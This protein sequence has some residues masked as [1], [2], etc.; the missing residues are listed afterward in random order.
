MHTKV[1]SR[2]FAT[3][4]ENFALRRFSNKAILGTGFGFLAGGA[5][6]WENSKV[7]NC[8]NN[9]FIPSKVVEENGEEWISVRN[10]P[11]FVKMPTQTDRTLH[12]VYK[13]LSAASALFSGFSIYKLLTISS[14]PA[15]GLLD[16]LIWLAG[17]LSGLFGSFLFWSNSGVIDAKK[18]EQNVQR[19]RDLVIKTYNLYDIIH[20]YGIYNA[21]EVSTPQELRAKLLTELNLAMHDLFSYEF[22]PRYKPYFHELVSEGIL[23]QSEAKFFTDLQDLHKNLWYE[24]ERARTILDKQVISLTQGLKIKKLQILP[25][26][27][28]LQKG[29]ERALKH[30]LDLISAKFQNSFAV[31]NERSINQAFLTNLNML[32]VRRDQ[33]IDEW[34][35]KVFTLRDRD[36]EIQLL[37]QEFDERKKQLEYQRDFSLRSNASLVEVA[38]NEMSI[39]QKQAYE[40]FSNEVASVKSSIGYES[41]AASL[42]KAETNTTISL[43]KS[44]QTFVNQC[45]LPNASVIENHARKFPPSFASTFL[46]DVEKKLKAEMSTSE[47][48]S[49]LLK[50]DTVDIFLKTFHY[51]LSSEK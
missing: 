46:I 45:M 31:L 50:F 29:A 26:S 27:K 36:E 30:D 13:I 15:T 39:E 9:L 48:A 51:E 20:K 49:S 17:S 14:N 43:Q 24:F 12:Y 34:A 35:N 18:L 22:I 28:F 1:F 19:R 32:T 38:K 5:Y 23:L 25:Q 6:L 37:Y 44:L 21:L 16:S 47:L 4:Q 7:H 8:S 10:A 41:K 42:S 2:K 40:R 11:V 3:F 33:K